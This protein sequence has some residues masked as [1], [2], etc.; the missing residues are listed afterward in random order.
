MAYKGT[1]SSLELLEYRVQGRLVAGNKSAE[2]DRSQI[3]EGLLCTET[4]PGVS[5]RRCTCPMGS[6]I[7]KAVQK[8]T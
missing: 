6:I 4:E 2:V 1:K 8:K 7:S 5:K 3:T